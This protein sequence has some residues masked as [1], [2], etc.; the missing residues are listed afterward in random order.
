MSGGHP[1]ARAP[2][3][4]AR[5]NALEL[6][7]QR[8]AASP[9]GGKLF[10]TVFPRIDRVLMPLTRGRLGMGVGQ[11]VLLL[12]TTGARSGQPR[13]TPVLYTAHGDDLVAIASKAGSAHHPAWYHNAM[14]HPDVGVEIGGLRLAFRARE[15][16]GAERDELWRAAVDNYTGFD[17]YQR[18][19][20][21]RRIPVVVLSPASP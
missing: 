9:L 16:Q 20:P 2:K 3:P 18:R 14:A 13:V 15:A 7:L 12:H 21:A 19:A 11:P 6:E 17:A 5:K 8:F 4:Q 10:I 1:Y